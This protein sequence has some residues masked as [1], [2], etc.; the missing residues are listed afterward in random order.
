MRLTVSLFLLAALLLPAAHLGAEDVYQGDVVTIRNGQL[1]RLTDQLQAQPQALN[2]GDNVFL[3]DRLATEDKALAILSLPDVGRYVMGPGTQIEIGNHAK[4]FSTTVA[5][6]SLWVDAKLQGGASLT[7]E[8]A[9]ASTGVRGTRFAVLQDDEG[10][11]VCLCAGEVEVTLKD[12][13]TATVTGGGR[14][15]LDA[16]GMPQEDHVSGH[17]IL[18][19][20][21]EGKK[22]RYD[23]CF[24]CHLVGGGLKKDW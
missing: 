9:L 15:P 21:G 5:S 8:T 17:D 3:E 23:F 7:V 16:K 20:L 4:A 13:S 11:D 10:A 2:V 1:K 19:R 24:Q 14:Y 6:G 12:G 18:R 22:A